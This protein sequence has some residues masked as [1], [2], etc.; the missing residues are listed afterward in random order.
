MRMIHHWSRS[1]LPTPVS[2]ATP[3]P[4][5]GKISPFKLATFAWG[6][7]NGHSA[8]SLMRTTPIS[9]YSMNLDHRYVPCYIHYMPRT[10]LL[11]P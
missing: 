3:N 7:S 2:I 6:P 10:T 8:H 1:P 4:V 9:F 5:L 11:W